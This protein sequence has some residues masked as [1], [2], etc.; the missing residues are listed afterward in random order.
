VPIAAAGVTLSL[1]LAAWLSPSAPARGTARSPHRDAVEL[2]ATI[3]Y[4]DALDNGMAQY[5]LHVALPRTEPGERYAIDETRAWIVRSDGRR[6]DVGAV[7]PRGRSSVA[8][9]LGPEQVIAGRRAQHPRLA[10]R[11]AVAAHR[12]AWF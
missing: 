7:H 5:A 6:D 12:A 3:A 10:G 1:G 9:N 2:I 4:A 11:G 8:V